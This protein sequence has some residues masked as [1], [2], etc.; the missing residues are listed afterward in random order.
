MK[1]NAVFVDRDGTI[2]IDVHYLNDPDKFEMYPGVGEGIK[3]LKVK[4]YKIIVI[5]NQSGIGRGYFT[6]QQLFRVHERM[7]TEFQKFDVTLDG[8]YYCPH[9]P[10]DHCN[11]RK[12]NTGL[13]E[14]AVQEHNIDVKKSFMLGDK[15]LDIEAGKKIGVKTILIPEPHLKEV[16][17][18]Q[19]NE[20]RHNPDFIANN[21]RSAVD[22]IL[23]IN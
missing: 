1:N 10:D 3:Q 5:T 11:C 2:N 9:H 22:W 18:S 6:E 19:K 14:K 20:W 17:L 23:D 15:M 7:I 8:I 12:P 16:L 4:G 13:F 21:F